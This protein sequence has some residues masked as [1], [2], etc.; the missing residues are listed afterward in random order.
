MDIIERLE[1]F[2]RIFRP[3]DSITIRHTDVVKILKLL[4]KKNKVQ[5][6]ESCPNLSERFYGRD[7]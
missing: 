5:Q 3:N 2:K 7:T 1:Q 6:T 4:K